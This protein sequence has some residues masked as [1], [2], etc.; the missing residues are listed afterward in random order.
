[1]NWPTA[2]VLTVVVIALGAILV[3][4]IRGRKKGKP[5]C[6]CGCSCAGC[7]MKDRCHR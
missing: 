5:H 7:A 2:V 1:M 6:S 4:R 3:W